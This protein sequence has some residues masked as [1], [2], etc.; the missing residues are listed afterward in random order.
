MQLNSSAREIFM[1]DSQCFHEL[2]KCNWVILEKPLSIVTNILMNS[3][4]DQI[5][6]VSWVIEKWDFVS[7]QRV[8]CMLR[9][10]Q[11]ANSKKLSESANSKKFSDVDTSENW[12]KFELSWHVLWC[13]K[14]VR[15]ICLL[16]LFTCFV[17]CNSLENSTQHFFF[18][19]YNQ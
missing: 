1:N 12:D 9:S 11:S 5:N 17:D 16:C 4:C 3:R 10:Q 14:I 7:R 19:F 2:W 13:W 15:W 18:N 8:A 6:S